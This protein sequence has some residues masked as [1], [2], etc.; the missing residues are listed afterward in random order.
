M[1]LNSWSPASSSQLLGLYVGDMWHGAWLEMTFSFMRNDDGIPLSSLI[2]ISPWGL[3]AATSLT[4][5]LISTKWRVT[6]MKVWRTAL[7]KIWYEPSP[8]HDVTQKRLA[9]KHALTSFTSVEISPDSTHSIENWRT[10]AQ[11]WRGLPLF[12]HEAEQ[13]VLPQNDARPASALK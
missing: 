8:P 2:R 10:A 9:G 12:W 7:R 4:E 6:G 3:A 11:R 13:H 1:S 5:P